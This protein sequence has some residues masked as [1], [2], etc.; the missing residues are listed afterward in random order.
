MSDR[1]TAALLLII[2]IAFGIQGWTYVSPGFTDVLG[3]RLFPLSI[4][5]LMV[6]LAIA[7]FVAGHA[8]KEW[9]NRHAWLVL[10]IALGTLA[11]YALLVEPLGFVVA[12]TAVFV[13]FGKLF[14]ARW[15][16]GLI[17][18]V[19]G[20]LV[21]YAL[22]VWALDLYLPIGSLFERWF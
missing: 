11:L 17:A 20:A 2:A 18:G 15:W 3:A 4:T 19:I 14:A 7:L 13:I 10:A 8:A 1:V 6:P 9:P 5:A 12:T 16:Q 22:F 21:L